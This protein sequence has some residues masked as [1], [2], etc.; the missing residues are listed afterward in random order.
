MYA[1]CRVCS[2]TC[3]NDIDNRSFTLLWHAIQGIDYKVRNILFA[4]ATLNYNVN[5]FLNQ[6]KQVILND[7]LISS[8]T[9]VYRVNR[10]HNSKFD[11]VLH[12]RRCIAQ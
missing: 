8:V 6:Y 11:D 12:N 1:K 7:M 4:T 10:M 3:L 9:S 5:N 2:I